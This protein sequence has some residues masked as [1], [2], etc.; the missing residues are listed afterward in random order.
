MS[1][2]STPPM[3]EE[4][5]V[6]KILDKRTE[7]DGSVKYLLKWKGYD[8]AD[9][10][11]EPVENLDCEALLQEFEKKISKSKKKR[12]RII[13]PDDQSESESPSVSTS[14]SNII[15][16]ELRKLSTDSNESSLDTKVV[17]DFERY[18]PEKILGVTNVG[19]PLKFLMRWKD[20]QSAT[21][22]LAKEANIICPLLVIDYYETRLK[23]FEPKKR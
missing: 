16:S 1:D 13:E 21:F 7:E 10:T 9:N 3:E 19:G 11:W 8:D 23:L 17:S 5:I 4:Y 2:E 20:F 6:E 18:E 15:K 14:N 12:K 22:V